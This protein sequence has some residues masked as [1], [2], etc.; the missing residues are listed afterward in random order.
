MNPLAVIGIATKVVKHFNDVEKIVNGLSNGGKEEFGSVIMED[1]NGK[2]WKIKVRWKG[3]RGHY[4]KIKPR[5]HEAEKIHAGPT[6][7]IDKPHKYK[8][9]LQEEWEA[10]A[11]FADGRS[12]WADLPDPELRNICQTIL[13]RLIH[14][15]C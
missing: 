6:A 4:L 8:K 13:N 15:N 2:G 9:I 1:S 5:D 7:Y 12:K 10:F 3:K 14:D 11:Q